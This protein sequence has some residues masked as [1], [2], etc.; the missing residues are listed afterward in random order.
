VYAEAC[1]QRGVFAKAIDHQVIHPE[2]RRIHP[3][4]ILFLKV[5]ANHNRFLRTENSHN[6]FLRIEKIKN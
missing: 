3:A 1:Q 6:R 4:T 5:M 2:A